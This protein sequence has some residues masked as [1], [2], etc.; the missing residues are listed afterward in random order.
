MSGLQEVMQQIMKC[1]KAG[2]VL[3]FNFCPSEFMDTEYHIF[4]K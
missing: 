2:E 4:V 3:Y 1:R